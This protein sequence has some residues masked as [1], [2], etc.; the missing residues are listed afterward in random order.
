MRPF[1]L[2]SLVVILAAL[3]LAVPTSA[4]ADGAT[5]SVRNSRFGKILTD[6]RGYTL[7]LFTRERTKRSRCYGQ[8]AVA[9][10]PLLTTGSPRAAGGARSRYLGTT[11]RSDGRRQVTYRGH[12]RL[13]LR[14]R[15][16]AAPGPVPERV[17]V[18]RAL[19]RPL[20]ERE[21][22]PLSDGQAWNRASR[23]LRSPSDES[24]HAPHFSV[25]TFV[26]IPT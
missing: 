2:A 9:W 1:A 15:E 8:C 23:A 25:L 18:R 22:D 21:G 12:P 13:L 4:M 3:A 10:P 11:R 7:Y 24:P 26:R 5:V 14:Q 17:P 16:A 6:G 20:A 19:A